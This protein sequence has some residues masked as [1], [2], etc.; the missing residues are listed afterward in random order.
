MIWNIIKSI[1]KIFLDPIKYSIFKSQWRSKNPHNYTYPVNKYFKIDKVRVGDYSYGP[2][3]IHYWNHND[4][5]L[6]IGSFCS[7]ADGVKFLLG[8]NHELSNLTTYPFK[9]YFKNEDEAVT[10]GP[11]IIKD[12]VWIG[13]NCILLSGITIGQG[14]VIAAG[15]VVTKSFPPYSIIGGNPAKLIKKRFDESVI[16]KLENINYKLIDENFIM[17]N[18]DHLYK[19]QSLMTII[20]QL[21]IIEKD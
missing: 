19:K 21:T 16:E 2:L 3:E 12:D 1:I 6:E 14:C 15:S 17:N 10:K 20:K 11:V 4:E 5:K 18:I 9:F 7:V 13:T 8:G